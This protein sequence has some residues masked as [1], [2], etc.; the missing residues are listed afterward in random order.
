MVLL[1]LNIPLSIINI[2]PGMFFITVAIFEPINLALIGAASA[3][4][5]QYPALALP[6]Y[7]ALLF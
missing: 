4:A 2:I 3:L 5:Q 6:I 7:I 1:L